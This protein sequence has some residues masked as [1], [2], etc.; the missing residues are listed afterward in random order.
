MNVTGI[1]VVNDRG[2][3]SMQQLLTFMFPAFSS[4]DAT[5][6]GS[7]VVK[8]AIQQ[9]TIQHAKTPRSFLPFPRHSHPSFY[10]HPRK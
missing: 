1:G 5:D 3:L 7:H 9:T 6:N 10:D 4:K 8:I 2:F